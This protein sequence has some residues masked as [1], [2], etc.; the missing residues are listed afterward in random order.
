MSRRAPA[1]GQGSAVDTPQASAKPLDA[2][3]NSTQ[4][5]AEQFAVLYAARASPHIRVQVLG[6]DRV[7][8]FTEGDAGVYGEPGAGPDAVPDAV[9][10]EMPNTG[11]SKVR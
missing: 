5:L 4:T 7:V 3:S 10:T 11:P 9:P 1:G 8:I 2:G 6:P